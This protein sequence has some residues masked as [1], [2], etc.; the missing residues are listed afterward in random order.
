MRWRPAAASADRSGL[1]QR[2]QEGVGDERIEAL[3]GAPFRRQAGR[4]G[5]RVPRLGRDLGEAGDG[6]DGKGG[7]HARSL[8]GGNAVE[9]EGGGHGARL[10]E[11]SLGF[12][13]A[14]PPKSMAQAKRRAGRTGG[15]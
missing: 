4:I 1:L 15:R 3:A 13:R 11:V 12:V 9:R 2:A 6:A 8:V 7:W 14:L 10:I 5:A